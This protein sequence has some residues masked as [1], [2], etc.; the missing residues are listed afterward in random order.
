MIRYWTVP[1]ES[2]SN[3][4]RALNGRNVALKTR[5]DAIFTDMATSPS[6]LFV[7]SPDGIGKLTTTRTLQSWCDLPGKCHCITSIQNLLLVGIYKPDDSR[8]VIMNEN[9]TQLSLFQPAGEPPV[10]VAVQS[11]DQNN[12]MIVYEDRSC[13]M[14]QIGPDATY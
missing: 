7:V 9:F 10:P 6:A 11:F 12:I 13:A 1:V 5:R 3:H 8:V 2:Q 14:M 4:A